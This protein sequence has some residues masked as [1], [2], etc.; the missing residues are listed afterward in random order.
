[1]GTNLSHQSSVKIKRQPRRRR[2]DPSVLDNASE[3][4]NFISA[5]AMLWFSKIIQ[6]KEL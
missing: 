2:D 5:A 3:A 1:V 6:N 4:L